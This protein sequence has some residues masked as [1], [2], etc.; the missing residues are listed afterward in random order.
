M[1]DWKVIVFTLLPAATAFSV[2][3]C[4]Q[5][6]STTQMG[7]DR[8]NILGRAVLSVGFPCESFVNAEQIDERGAIL[9]VVCTNADVYLATVEDGGDIC[10]EPIMYGDPGLTRQRVRVLVFPDG[11]V[12]ESGAGASDAPAIAPQSRCTPGADLG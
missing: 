8:D 9:R 2:F 11:T 6:S 5:P 3:G 12:R 4:A 10:I 7:A 1:S